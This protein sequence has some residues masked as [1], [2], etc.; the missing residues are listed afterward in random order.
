M[1][2]EY[3]A[4]AAAKLGAKNV[5]AIDNDPQAVLSSKENVA[6]NNCENII[7]TIHS[8]DQIEGIK[9]DL[10]IANILAN[11]LLNWSHCFQI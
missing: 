5:I 1:A 10:L 9:C 4:I 11:P 7:S 8:I 6:K 3:L 2:L